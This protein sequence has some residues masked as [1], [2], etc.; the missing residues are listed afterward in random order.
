MP[1]GRKLRHRGT[2]RTRATQLRDQVGLCPQAEE[3]RL[4]H[5]SRSHCIDGTYVFTAVAEGQKA[6]FVVSALQQPE[7]T[8]SHLQLN[9]P[10]NSTQPSYGESPHT[11]PGGP[12]P[13]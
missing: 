4:P 13:L 10:N 2:Q 12:S 6:G 11:K 9:R 8:S 3:G 1:H 5:H 7:H